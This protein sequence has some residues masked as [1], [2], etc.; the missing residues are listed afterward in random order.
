MRM[1]FA[2][3]F[4]VWFLFLAPGILLSQESVLPEFSRA[5]EQ[6]FM[7]E[8]ATIED[9]EKVIQNLTSSDDEKFSQGLYF[10]KFVAPRS[11]FAGYKDLIEK[12]LVEIISNKKERRIFQAAETAFAFRFSKGHAEELS[13]KE[14][15]NELN[16]VKAIIK[17]KAGVACDPTPEHFISLIEA[18]VE[19]KEVPSV[20][21][22]SMKGTFSQ[23]T[24]FREIVEVAFSMK[25]Y[26]LAFRFSQVILN[27]PSEFNKGSHDFAQDIL[28]QLKTTKPELFLERKE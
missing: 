17:E 22:K 3:S 8:S 20:D 13:F 27:H 26:G 24:L 23:L 19:N 15:D 18:G 1:R 21:P 28:N 6:K 25:Y 9:A 14:N 11:K 10:S 4:V 12:V 2:S 5:L 7:G 16:L